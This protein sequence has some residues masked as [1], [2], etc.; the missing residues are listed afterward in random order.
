MTQHS[1]GPQSSAVAEFGVVV[2]TDIG[3]AVT[4]AASFAVSAD[5]DVLETHRGLKFGEVTIRGHAIL[6]G[7]LYLK[8]PIAP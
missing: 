6:A 7:T 8:E 4:D 2:V 5:S 1:G 3:S